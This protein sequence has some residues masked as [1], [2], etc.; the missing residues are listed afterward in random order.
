MNPPTS[1]TESPRSQTIYKSAIVNHESCSALS[2][3]HKSFLWRRGQPTEACRSTIRKVASA[4]KSRISR[5]YLPVA[6]HGSAAS[7]LWSNGQRVHMEL[8][9]Q[10]QWGSLLPSRSQKSLRPGSRSRITYRE[11]SRN[12][13]YSSGWHTSKA[14]WKNGGSH[15]IYSTHCDLTK[16]PKADYSSTIVL[17]LISRRQLILR[18]CIARG[19][20]ARQ[21]LTVAREAPNHF[22]GAATRTVNL[23][24]IHFDCIQHWIF[25]PVTKWNLSSQLS[26]R[27]CEFCKVGVSPV[28]LFRSKRKIDKAVAFGSP[29]T[30]R[31]EVASNMA[32][33]VPVSWLYLTSNSAKLSSPE[34][35][36]EEVR[37]NYCWIDSAVAAFERCQAFRNRAEKLIS[38][39][40]EI[41]KAVAQWTKFC[42]NRANQIVES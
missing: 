7:W 9:H 41:H 25:S 22:T 10:S 6:C 17:R 14:I 11:Q 40:I 18:F 19:P 3:F 16:V 30:D 33:R 36:V 15:N 13:G 35:R 34:Q 27:K 12:Q 42:Q 29:A 28:N 37:S 31:D 39:E 8:R 38:W 4:P 26:P 5:R 21:S 32:S 20:N 1:H 23:R 24:T 2:T